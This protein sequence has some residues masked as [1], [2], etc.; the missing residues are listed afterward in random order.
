M[1]EKLEKR[2]SLAHNINVGF[3]VGKR[4][5]AVDNLCST[6]KA[7]ETPWNNDCDH[8]HLLDDSCETISEES[9]LEE[10]NKAFYNIDKILS[11]E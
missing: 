8:S 9:H 2:Q 4:D 11:N 7:I 10:T 1:L 3:N 6:K 5:S